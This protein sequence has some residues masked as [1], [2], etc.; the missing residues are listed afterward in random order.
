LTEHPIASVNRNP[1]G[2]GNLMTPTPNAEKS[3]SSQFDAYS[4]TYNEAVNSALS[5]TGMKVDFFTRVKMNY[6]IDI[7][8]C[9]LPSADAANVLDVGCGVGNAHPLLVDRVGRL[10]GI[11]VS[12]RCI[13]RARQ[14]N[15]SVQYATFE[16]INL[17]F[18]DES[19]DVVFAVCVFHHVPLADRSPLASEIRRVLRFGGL[20]VIFEHNPRS[21]LT[22]RVVNN[23]EFDQDAI[24]LD[25]RTSELL[26]ATSGFRNINTHF[27]LTVP[28]Q[29]RILRALDRL[30]APLPIGAQYYTTGRV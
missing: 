3:G 26:M 12:Q 10:T 5:F 1:S 15:P 27:I 19:F 8:Q 20:F 21:P 6:L 25:R 18:D 7:I 30:F 29:G 28:A 11:D 17:P 24:L 14:K 23:C 13:D 9:A 16:G 4:D 22:T 2:K